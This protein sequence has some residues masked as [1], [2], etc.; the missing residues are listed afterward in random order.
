MPAGFDRKKRDA[1]AFSLLYEDCMTITDPSEL[2]RME[3]AF[4]QR[5]RTADGSF[6]AAV[7]ST[8][9]YCRPSCPAR[10]PLP[11]NVEF[12]AD[13][14]AA[15]AAGYRACRRCLPDDVARDEEAVALALRAIEEA[16]EAPRLGELAG[17]TG[18]SATHFQRV[19]KRHVGLSPAA[20][21]RALRAERA[22]AMLSAGAA[23]TET[24]H[25]AGFSGPSRFYAAMEGRLGMTPSAWARGGEG[26]TIR[27]AVVPTTLGPMLVA[28]TDKGVCRL[29]F[30]EGREALEDRF[31]KAR[32]E[33]G[34][35][36]FGSLAARVA[37]AVEHPGSDDDIPLDVRGT[38]FQEAV[39]R[40]LRRIP[41]GETRSYAQIAAAAGNPKA[42]R[43]AGSANGANPVAVLVPCHRVLR[44]GGGIGGYAYGTEIKRELLR[45]EGKGG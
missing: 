31:P 43:A 16:E 36:E 5:D 29:S 15:R 39:W 40:E 37:E 26:V 34:G 14:D 28:A 2:A 32:L 30:N 18:Y 20:Y 4:A 10:R 3:T 12:F 7:K 21:A 38:A 45:R 11:E 13:A 33:E 27:W 24:I 17:L 22:E 6:V 25:A 42:V 8:A 23:V 35:A 9:I 19:F 44:T 41:P 1:R